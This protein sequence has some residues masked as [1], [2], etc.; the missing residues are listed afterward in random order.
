LTVAASRA[1]GSHGLAIVPVQERKEP[2][3]SDNKNQPIEKIRVAKVQFS[4]FRNEGENGPYY[5]A[6]LE[7]AYKDAAGNWKP[8]SRYTRHELINLA[9]AALLAE[10]KI[11]E[12]MYH[13]RTAAGIAS[14]VAA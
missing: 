1:P 11:S 5:I 9:N 7:N 3:M 4:I 13:E 12:L 6:D 14:T 8:T 10:A 2:T